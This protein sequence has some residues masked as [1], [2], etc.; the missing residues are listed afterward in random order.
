MII[1]DNR[2]SSDV[3]TGTI[4]DPLRKLLAFGNVLFEAMRPSH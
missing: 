4:A 2:E 1:D 3:T